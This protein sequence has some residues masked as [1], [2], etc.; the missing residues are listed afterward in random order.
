[1]LQTGASPWKEETVLTV[2][3]WVGFPHAYLLDVLESNLL[4]LQCPAYSWTSDSR[5]HPTPE[6][7][8]FF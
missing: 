1:M 5:I 7:E 3:G 2:K 8:F 4:N 6:L